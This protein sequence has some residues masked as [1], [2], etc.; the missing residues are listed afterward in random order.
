MSVTLSMMS[1]QLEPFDEDAVPPP[2]GPFVSGGFGKIGDPE[3]GVRRVAFV[4]VPDIQQ[5]AAHVGRPCAG[6]CCLGRA[7]GVRH[8]LAAAVAAPAPVVE[9]AGDLVAL[10][11]ALGQ[12][13]AHVPAVAVEDLHDPRASRRKPRA[14]CRTPGSSAASRPGSPL[15]RPGSASPARTWSARRRDR[16]PGR[17]PRWCR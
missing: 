9:R 4:V 13:A 15:R 11:G 16:F 12:V 7:L 5:A 10:D 8:Q 17:R 2:L 3:S 14:W 6:A 1:R